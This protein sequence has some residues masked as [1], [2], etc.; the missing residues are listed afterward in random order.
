[1]ELY[2]ILYTLLTQVNVATLIESLNSNYKIE[3]FTIHD[4]FATNANYIELLKF[5]VKNTFLSLYSKNILIDSYYDYIRKIIELNQ[6]QIV[7]E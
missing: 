4:C 2:Q 6:F 1:M 7:K 5:Q 3:L